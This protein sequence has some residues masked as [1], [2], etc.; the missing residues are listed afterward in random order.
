MFMIICCFGRSYP[1]NYVL[2]FVFTLSESYMIAGITSTYDKNIVLMAG[3]GT[4]LVTVSLTAYA[5]FTKVNIEVFYALAWVV[6]MAML[7]MIIIGAV[8]KL[9][10]LNILYCS[11]GL[12]FYSLFLIIDTMMICNSN[13][14][15]GGY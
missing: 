3:L 11:L 5:M 12:I 4:A 2:L 1:A 8:L 6:Y 13:K 14:S 7:P 15:M 9:H 10:A